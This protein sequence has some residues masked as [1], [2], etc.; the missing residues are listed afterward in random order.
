MNTHVLITQ[1]HSIINEWPILFHIYP[2]HSPQRSW[3]I[4]SKFQKPS[5]LE[6][7]SFH[8]FRIKPK[9]LHR[10]CQVLDLCWLLQLQILACYSPRLRPRQ[11]SL[12]SVPSTFMLFLSVP[13][14][15]RLLSMPRKPVIIFFHPVCWALAAHVF[16][17]TLNITFSRGP[18]LR[19]GV[20]LLS[21]HLLL[22]LKLSIHNFV[23]NHVKLP[24]LLK[25]S[26][27]A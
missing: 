5:H 14:A 16:A 24:S 8:G 9:I 2:T 18:Q 15:F 27:M 10:A 21:W 22:L 23:V 26:S 12:P 17:I 25:M 11:A 6:G 19:L 3:I 4:G 13:A 7:E 20:P 1:L